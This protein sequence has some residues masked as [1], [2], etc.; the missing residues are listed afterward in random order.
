MHFARRIGLWVWQA[1]FLAH[2]CCAWLCQEALKPGVVT[3]KIS[4][5]LLNLVLISV[6]AAAATKTHEN[7][8][9]IKSRKEE[10]VSY[11]IE[12]PLRITGVSKCA[13]QF[14]QHYVKMR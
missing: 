2:I 11:T 10:I 3:R 5:E 14:R 4:Q 8:R 9:A 13:L 7:K 6:P 12:S 1:F